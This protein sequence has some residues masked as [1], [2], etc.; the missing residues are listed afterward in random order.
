[1]CLN[2]NLVGLREKK[3]KTIIDCPQNKAVLYLRAYK[4][5]VLKERRTRKAYEGE[6]EAK[7]QPSHKG[8]NAKV[9]LD[10]KPVGE[11]FGR[12]VV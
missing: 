4:I 3:R 7:T 1:M 5:A 11:R 12:I 8:A 6:S 9:C 10:Y 2:K